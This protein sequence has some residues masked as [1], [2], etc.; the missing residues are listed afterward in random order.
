MLSLL[1][2]IVIDNVIWRSLNK[3]LMKEYSFK[4]WPKDDPPESGFFFV[5]KF[6]GYILWFDNLSLTF[7]LHILVL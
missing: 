6:R 1:I 5:R 2:F 3:D 4:E 7:V